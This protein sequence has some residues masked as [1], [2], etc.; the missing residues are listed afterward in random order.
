MPFTPQERKKVEKLR[1]K[2][3]IE[4]CGEVPSHEWPNGHLS[5]FSAVHE[6]GK[7]QFDPYAARAMAT[8]DAPWTADIKNHA[9][10]LS[11]RAKRCVRRN[12]STWR[13]ACEPYALARLT[14]EVVCKFCRKRVW[15]SEIEATSEG[16][17]AKAEALRIR[18]RKR[19]P[20][21]CS[22]DFRHGDFMEA[23]GLNRIF[24]HREDEIIH[25]ESAVEEELPRKT[26]PDAIYGLR[27]TRNI[28]NLLND[29]ACIAEPKDDQDM[30][31]HECLGEPPLS[32][33]GDPLLFPFLLLEANADP[34]A[35][36]GNAEELV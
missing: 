10:E 16:N 5:T 17:S 26:K 2:Y 22:R 8:E 23:V 3:R 21:R 30:L 6:L 32:E 15:R 9:E 29:N 36:A 18:Q 11:E 35:H 33:E 12:E 31:V 24:G 28:E 25:H 14:S 1:Q 13:F 20:C 27:Q 34:I 19:E 4:F 7:K